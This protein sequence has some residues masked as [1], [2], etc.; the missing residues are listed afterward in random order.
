[1][2]LKVQPRACVVLSCSKRE[3]QNILELCLASLGLA[4]DLCLD[5]VLTGDDEIAR[6]NHQFLGCVGPTNV[7]S[8]PDEAGGGYIVLS[9]DAL[10][11]E[12]LLYAQPVQEHFVRLLSHA[13]L[14]LAGFEH[15]QIMADLTEGAVQDFR[16]QFC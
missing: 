12:A 16:S 14:H 4:D 11:R 13:I 15:G 9:I 6:L 8:F 2:A 10:E 1:M 5:L 7:L 3:V